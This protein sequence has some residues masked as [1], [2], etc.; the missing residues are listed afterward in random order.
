M[1]GRKIKKHLKTRQAAQKPTKVNL[2]KITAHRRLPEHKLGVF[3]RPGPKG[4]IGAP[5]AGGAACRFGFIQPLQLIT[6][7]SQQVF[8][9]RNVG[10]GFDA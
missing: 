5:S 4:D 10:V 8:P 1:T 3:T 2:S 6:D 7:A 9:P